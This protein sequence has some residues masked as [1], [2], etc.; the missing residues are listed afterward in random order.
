MNSVISKKSN[1]YRIITVIAAITASVILPQIFHAIG[2]I[3]GT[4]NTIGT[5]LL[6]MHIPVILAGFIGG[7]AVGLIAGIL[8]PLASFAISSMPAIT[9][10]PF[11]IIE[12]GVYGLTAG[13]VSGVKF[14][15]FTK[16]IAV[17]VAG[18]AARALAV[19]AAIYILGNTSF[20]IASIAEFITAGLF[21]I[22]LQ[23][24]FIP[25]AVDKIRGRSDV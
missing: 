1:A 16:L 9:L 18:R 15:S 17:Q 10:L 5:A 2:I 25:L 3:S 22:V 23:W 6:P 14:S 7:P 13:L 8:S 11:M 24:A 4:G 20:T 21:G 19:L 12:L